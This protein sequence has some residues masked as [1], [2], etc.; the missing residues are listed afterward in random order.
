[1]KFDKVLVTG[2]A[3]FIGSH[4]VDALVESDYSVH[5]IDNL[6][7]Q[8]HGIKRR[9]PDYFNKKAILT[10]SDVSNTEILM[11]VIKDVDAIIHLAARVGVAQSMYD[12]EKY[13][14][15]NTG[16]TASMLNLLVNEKNSVK[17]L[18]VASS[19][20][21]YGEGKY[22]CEKCEEDRYPALR[23]TK[24][25]DKKIWEH[26]CPDC[27]SP[28]NPLPTDEN[29]PQIPSSIY[30]MSKR[31]QEEMCL[32]IGKTYGIPTVAL[33]YLNV[34]GPRQ[35]LSNP[36][37][38]VCAIF[39]QRI[40]NQKSPFVFEDGKQ[41]RDF[42]HVRDV[43][44]ANILALESNSANY[45]SINIG[46]G[47]STSILQIAEHLNDMFN[48]SMV[49]Y[50][51]GEYRTGDVRH[52]YGDITKARNLLH[53]EPSIYLEKGMP[54][55]VNWS[56]LNKGDAQDLFEKAYNELKSRGLT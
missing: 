2:G 40:L 24:Q 11:D 4:T 5:V 27:N 49:P 17:K 28:L 30:A 20:S 22:Y 25:M 6:D 14:A 56:K 51:S 41:L 36:Y 42:I 45:Q 43:A 31:H 19:M 10:I 9:I 48:S 53:F 1:M 46:T 38:G 23:S 35:S 54:D 50:I 8:V 26:L 7:P 12:I 15:A 16:S 44:K 47:K 21:I 13:V 29:K 52:C 18:V 33:R 39:A 3:G 32:L 34:Y 37:T 55:L